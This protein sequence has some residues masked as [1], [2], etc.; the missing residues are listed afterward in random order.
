MLSGMV[1]S[2]T[3]T[4]LPHPRCTS[5][6]QEKNLTR[7]S[8]FSNSSTSSKLLIRTAIYYDV[9]LY[10]SSIIYFESFYM[11]HLPSNGY[12]LKFTVPSR[13]FLQLVLS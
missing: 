11:T 4:V 3:E 2:V 5:I 6:V 9:I 13:C 10:D 8:L 1:F 7:I 12:D